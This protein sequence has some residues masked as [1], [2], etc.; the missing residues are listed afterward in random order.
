MRSALA[1]T[2]LALALTAIAI[3]VVGEGSAP[4]I[5]RV[6]ELYIVA[7]S[8]LPNGTSV[9]VYAK[10]RVEVRCPG[11]GH[12]YLE[13]W[14][15]TEIDTQAS[16]RVAAM[17]AAMVAG[18]PFSSCDYLA[19]I[20][21][22]SSIVGGP[23][24]SLAMAVAFAAA[25]M[26]LPLDR[27]VV[28]TGMI[29]PDGSVGPVGGLLYKLRAAAEVGARVFLV[30]YGQINVTVLQTVVKR[31]GPLVMITQRPK[32]VNLAEVGKQLGV[33]VEQVATVFQALSYAT[34]GRYRP[35]INASLATRALESARE[36]LEPVVREWI[37]VERKE[38]DEALSAVNSSW[39]SVSRELPP[40]LRSV[41]SSIVEQ[42]IRS[43]E[44]AKEVARGLEKQGLLYAAA[45]KYFYALVL[46][47]RLE[48]L[49]K[50]LEEPKALNESAN[51]IASRGEELL[52]E[53]EKLSARQVHLYG[54]S[55][56][57]DVAQRVFEAIRSAE[58]AEKLSL[59]SL[60][61]L[62]AA[63]TYLGY[64]DARL[65]SA[66]MWMKLLESPVALGGPVISEGI[67]WRA[68][69][70]VLDYARTV[71]SYVYAL[72]SEVG[73]SKPSELEEA[74]RALTMAEEFRS[75][76]LR[77]ALA[78]EGLSYAYAALAKLFALP[79]TTEV[80]NESISAL[81]AILAK[82]GALP[83]DVALYLELARGSNSVE[84]LASVAA[85]LASTLSLYLEAK[86]AP[87]PSRASATTI[88]SVKP[89]VV[90]SV[91]SV[92]TTTTATT[93]VT[94]VVTKLVTTSTVSVRTVTTTVTAP[95]AA[96][97]REGPWV[98]VAA[99]IIALIALALGIA[100]Y[101]RVRSVG[102]A[103]SG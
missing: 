21:S 56:A 96:R 31:A 92:T 1:L 7:V 84:L 13:T 3:Q 67:V 87:W 97:P 95:T 5:D 32:V 75:P 11:S 25:L 22:N 46:A 83:P 70:S 26:D 86:P 24:A 42:G 71:G 60:D 38:L 98:G 55:I 40:Y 62:V 44:L 43:I 2:L 12:V 19:S 14:P 6:R 52:K 78:I 103:A 81:V 16:A 90:T 88:T 54:V 27:R 66:E 20:V 28:M 89:V 23:S 59:S 64:A 68:S 93:T 9:G 29:M 45:S 100:G 48:Y 15:L 51:A 65:L 10:L 101:A 49:C 50:L 37:S 36:S 80:L 102:Y 4:I 58:E 79:T 34:D 85:R 57:M 77:L 72:A 69:Q 18:I 99:L 91:K 53:L 35:P 30:P 73:V 17:V 33:E 41:V 8:T 39:S 74:N 76:V 61:S 47:K 82:L 63:A 94:K